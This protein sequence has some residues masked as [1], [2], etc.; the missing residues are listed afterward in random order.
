MTTKGGRRFF[1]AVVADDSASV[2]LKW[3]NSNPTFMKRIWKIGK[4]AIIIGEV[5]QFGHQRE[6]HHPDVEWLA[7]GCDV[8]EFLAADQVNFGKI[9]PVY[10]LTEGLSQKDHAQGNEGSRGKF[11]SLHS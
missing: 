1:E 3:F 8:Q 7:E 6:V 9:V 10:P 2:P 11:R 4:T 5:S